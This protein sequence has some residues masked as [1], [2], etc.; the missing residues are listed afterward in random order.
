MRT[1]ATLGLMLLAL[2]LAPT[3]A[4]ADTTTVVV[5]GDTAAAENQPGW[6][7]DRDP[8]NTTP[9]E[10]T[11]AA[12]KIGMGSLYVEPIGDN[13]PAK[14]IAELFLLSDL[15][16]LEKVSYDIQLGPNS[17]TR[18]HD[19]E[20]FY[21]NV[22][23]NLP[24]S[25]VDNFYDCRFDYTAQSVAAE[26]W[27]T[28]TVTPDTP[29]DNVRSRNNAQCPTTLVGMPDG[30]TVRLVSLSLGDTSAGDQGLDG[31]FDN[32]VVKQAGASTTFDLEPEPTSKD[33]CK[34]GGFADYSFKNQGQCVSYVASNGRSG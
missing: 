17:P 23:T 11:T 5:R 7:F 28:A 31:Y 14:F 1:L 4:L 30:S 2:L 33:A 21:M 15:D 8:A 6:M 10:F 13:P 27:T 9:F 25:P 32:V 24:D 12:A 3:S 20:Q 29:P 19:A 34:K 26:I 18:T 22:Y 16:D